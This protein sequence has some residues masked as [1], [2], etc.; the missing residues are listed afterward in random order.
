MRGHWRQLIAVELAV[1][2][3]AVGIAGPTVGQGV[4]LSTAHAAQTLALQTVLDPGHRFTIS[5]PV[6]WE[7]AT[8][9]GDHALRAT[10]PAPE[11][12]LPDSVDVIVREMPTAISAQ[13]CVH[14]AEEIMRFAIR[15]WTTLSEN[16]GTVADIPAY[17]HAYTWQAKTGQERWSLQVCVTLGHR[18]FMLIGTAAATPEGTREAM[19]VLPSI[20]D[21]FRPVGTAARAPDEAARSHLGAGRG[22]TAAERTLQWVNRTRSRSAGP[23]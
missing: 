4:L 6:T 14:Q 19:P 20:I 21:T 15:S 9:T 18:A 16:P 1:A 12:G 2:V 8:S 11:T 7:T 3:I 5:M 10:A 13:N 22:R 23:Q 17:T